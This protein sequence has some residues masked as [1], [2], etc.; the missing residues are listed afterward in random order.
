M[1][2]VQKM[3][4]L[5]LLIFF[6]V[7]TTFASDIKPDS[8]KTPR[9]IELQDILAWKNITSTAL[10]NNG[11]WFAYQV[12][13][14][15]GDSEILIKQTK[16]DSTYKFPIGE[17]SRSS[18][19]FSEDSKWVAFFIYPTEKEKKKLKKQKKKSYN[20]FIHI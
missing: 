15:K 14:N 12:A 19:K 17:N 3:F 11:D 2:H 9:S 20:K 13:P 7:P 1:K 8:T 4:V 16:G 6:L 5:L 18:I 10:S